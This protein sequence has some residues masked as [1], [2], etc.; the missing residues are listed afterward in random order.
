MRFKKI[1]AAFMVILIAANCYSVMAETTPNLMLDGFFTAFRT[2]PQSKDGVTMVA[3]RE[4]AGYVDAIV[5]WR[6]LQKTAVLTKSNTELVLT[7][8]TKRAYLNG[9]QIELPAAPMF[10]DG[11]YME[12]I[13]V[14]MRFV[15]E[16]FGALVGWDVKTNT[17]I[18]TTGKD[19]LKIMD[20]NQPTTQNAIVM[21]YDE[22][23]KNAYSANSTLLNLGESKDVI[24]EK[25]G[26]ILDQITFMGHI[27]SL[28]SQQFTNAL[29]AL[30]QLEDTMRDI[31]TN[32]QMVRESIEYMFRGTLASV[33]S[34][35]MDM[36]LLKENIKLQTNDVN[37]TKL[38]LDV[39]MES[40]NNLKDAELRL[41]QSKVNQELLELM[42]AQGQ[43]TLGQILML[44]MDREI[45]IHFEPRM[46]P[47]PDVNA[48]VSHALSNDPMLKIKDTAV[49]QAQ[50]ALDTFTDSSTDSRL[51][52][53]NNLI[54]ASRNYDDTRRNLEAAIRTAHS[55][56]SQLQQNQRTLELNLEKALNDYKTLSANYLAGMVT[57]FDLDAGKVAILKAE[58]DIAKNAYSYW[59]LHYG[60]MHPYLLLSSQTGAQAGAQTGT[61][62]AQTGTA[63][64]MTGQMQD[65]IT[66]QMQDAITG[67]MQDALTGQLQDALS[68]QMPNSLTGQMP[69]NLSGQ[70]PGNLNGQI[71]GA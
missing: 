26:N 36:Q 1:A 7:I 45:I 65:A 30:R 66:G 21:N 63:G 70:I 2:K 35:K 39:G 23:L 20:I 18:L 53:H 69:G 33:A 19:P 43:S 68:G 4:I 3:M 62:G 27:L 44:P 60:L 55:Q 59:V 31:P 64:D 6:D 38:K 5:T 51:E 67:Q 15:A 42:I 57:I 8:G 13:L 46:E 34:N 28:D 48:L 12:D 49:K 16:T 17:V 52:R 14:P 11:K 54:I 50:Y 71:P 24:N 10:N 47:L 61:A 37:N 32:E 22:A 56:L 41:S 29:R 9:A 40:A 58:I 25:R